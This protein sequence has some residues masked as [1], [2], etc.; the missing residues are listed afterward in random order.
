[1]LRSLLPS[2]HLENIDR[3]V[4]LKTKT[5][6]LIWSGDTLK[7]LVRSAIENHI[8]LE[9]ADFSGLDLRGVNFSRGSFVGALFNHCDLRCASFMFANLQGVDLTG[10]RLSGARL[11]GACLDGATLSDT[12]F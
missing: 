8:L 3:M 6:R 4:T 2:F 1:M 10:A 9:D 5:G 12:C 7:Q 11:T